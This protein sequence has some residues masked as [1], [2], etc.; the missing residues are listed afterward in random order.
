MQIGYR[1]LTWMMVDRDIAY[2]SPSSVYRILVK[3]ALNNKWTKPAGEPKKVGFDQPT[4]VHEQWHTDISFINF[5]GTFLYL[6]CVLDGFSRAILAWDIRINMETFDVNIVLYKAC[7]IWILNTDLKPRIITDNGGQFI[8][9]EFKEALNDSGITHSRTSPNHP[10]S[11]GKIERFHGTAK[12]ES[13]RNMPKID[14][15]QIKNEFGQFIN[16]YNTERL[17]SA[18][19]YVAPFDVI[20]NRKDMILEQRK[21]KLK[22]G[23]SNRRAFFQKNAN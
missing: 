11:N 8:S 9:K 14:I 21:Q 22:T 4:T 13:L 16:F 2:L 19:D 12:Q 20:Y 7:S 17:H 6:I 5:R 18:I 10:Q 1:R 3:A 23:R 15:S